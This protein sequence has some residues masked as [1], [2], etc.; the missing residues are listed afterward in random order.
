M[1]LRAGVCTPLGILWG[2]PAYPSRANPTPR[3][4]R[5]VTIDRSTQARAQSSPTRQPSKSTSV[6]ISANAP[7]FAAPSKTGAHITTLPGEPRAR[8]AANLVPRPRLAPRHS[9]PTGLAQ[10]G[11]ASHHL[12]G[13]S[14]APLLTLKR[15]RASPPSVEQQ[16]SA[17]NRT[18]GAPSGPQSASTYASRSADLDADAAE[19]ELHAPALSTDDKKN[20]ALRWWGRF[21]LY[22]GLHVH[23][24]SFDPTCPEARLFITSLVRQF[25]CFVYR[26][27]GNSVGDGPISPD[28]VVRYW[29][30]V[31]Q[32]H[33]G[34]NIDLS[35]ANAT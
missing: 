14:S 8:Y 15:K 10:T 33:L 2:Q 17:A 18:R 32:F 26:C 7:R 9:P 6:V 1:V 12:R 22:I 29:N 16:I 24:L 4:A 25:L 34:L 31:R 27:G 20:T 30:Q 35:F 21:V 11:P 23:L 28:S 3:V 5:S 19:T 13:S